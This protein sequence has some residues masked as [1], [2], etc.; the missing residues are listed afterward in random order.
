MNSS[1]VVSSRDHLVVPQPLRQI[2]TPSTRALKR[3]RERLMRH[4]PQNVARRRRRAADGWS[5]GGLPPFQLVD[6]M[7]VSNRGAN[8]LHG[9]HYA[10]GPLEERQIRLESLIAE[11]PLERDELC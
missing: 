3:N 6:A 8:L 10:A 4:L 7:L 11:Q 1:C 9:R 5:W 2:V